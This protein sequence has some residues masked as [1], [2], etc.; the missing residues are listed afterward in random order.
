MSVAMLQRRHCLVCIQELGCHTGKPRQRV[1]HNRSKSRIHSGRQCDY[2]LFRADSTQSTGDMAG[3]L[4]VATRLFRWSEE[5]GPFASSVLGKT[6][7]V[8]EQAFQPLRG[9]HWIPT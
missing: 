4:R 1:F 6:G 5:Q 8:I 2:I 7:Y 3:T 9:S